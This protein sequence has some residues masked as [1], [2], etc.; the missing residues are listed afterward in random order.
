MKVTSGSSPS[1]A[2]FVDQLYSIVITAGTHKAPSIIVA[3]AAKIIEN[4]QRDVNIALVNELSQIFRLMNID[5][6]DVLSAASTKWNFHRYTPGLV[7]GHCIGVVLT[8]YLSCVT[9]WLQ[10]SCPCR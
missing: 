2:D 10:L 7:G 8:T 9:T 5:T 4:I 1:S 6:Q 3:E